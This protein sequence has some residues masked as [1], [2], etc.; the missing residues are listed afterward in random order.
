MKGKMAKEKELE[1][2]EF[3]CDW[4]DCNNKPYAEVYG[5]PKHKGD[6]CNGW[7]YLCRKHFSKERKNPKKLFKF[8][9]IIKKTKEKG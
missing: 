8:W 6:I 1:E 3:K 2:P 7:C 4:R 9:W 5:L